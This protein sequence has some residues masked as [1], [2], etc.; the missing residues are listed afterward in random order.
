[1]NSKPH[2]LLLDGLRGVAALMVL[3]YHLFEAVAFAAGDPEQNMFHGFLGVDFFLVL[4][5]F[6]MGYAYDERLRSGALTFEAFVKRRLIRL[7]PMVVIGVL[8]GLAAFL[9]QGSVKWDGTQVSLGNVIISFVLALFLIPSPARLDARGNTEIF[10][11]NG[12]HWSL[13]FEYIGSVLYGLLLCRMKDKYLKMW[14]LCA[15]AGLLAVGF[16][17]GAGNIAYGWSSEPLNMLGGALRMLFAYPMG[18]LLSRMFR[19]R[20][21]VNLKSYIFTFCALALVALLC[22]PAIGVSKAPFFAKLGP[23]QLYYELFCVSVAFPAIIWTAARGGV[24]SKFSA[25]AVK[26]LGDLSYPLYAVHYPL[27]YLNIWWINEGMTPFGEAPWATPAALFVIAV[28]LGWLCFKLYDLPLRK[29]LTEK[30]L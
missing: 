14:V 17:G 7:H 27:I 19:S 2:Y 24:S 8:F 3:V 10:P 13:F 22:V 9:V 20:E 5:G 25:A 12:P 30:F 15:F 29:K 4:S 18:L 21:P 1:M 6:V 23:L 16:S 26:F 28:A 11:L